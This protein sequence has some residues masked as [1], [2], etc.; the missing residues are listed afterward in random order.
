MLGR[1]REAPG[2]AGLAVLETS[3]RHLLHHVIDLLSRDSVIM[4]SSS[5]PTSRAGP[6]DQTSA[7][8]SSAASCDGNHNI[9]VR[10]KHRDIPTRADYSTG[11][12]K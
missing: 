1:T 8:P 3:S 11:G 7:D 12:T 2:Y 6:A 4:P 9:R 5:L 10:S